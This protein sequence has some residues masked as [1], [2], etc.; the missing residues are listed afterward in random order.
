MP[1][2]SDLMAD[3]PLQIPWT[4]VDH[5]QCGEAPEYS[6]AADPLPVDLGQLQ[7]VTQL[8]GVPMIL[9]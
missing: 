6:P 5:I 3:F 9:G 4:Q 7:A 2:K 1:L 8:A